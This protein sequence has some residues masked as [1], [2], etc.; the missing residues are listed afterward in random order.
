MSSLFPPQPSRS[1]VGRGPHARRGWAVQRKRA[2]SH[3]QRQREDRNAR[4][5]HAQALV[6]SGVAVAGAELAPTPRA[7]GI[8]PAYGRARRGSARHASGGYKRQQ[9]LALSWNRTCRR[10]VATSAEYTRAAP[11]FYRPASGCP[12]RWQPRS[13][14]KFHCARPVTRFCFQAMALFG[15]GCSTGSTGSTGANKRV[16]LH[17]FYHGLCWATG[18]HA[19]RSNM[20]TG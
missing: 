8:A 15:C 2:E 10:S 16:G 3:R 18:A 5:A 6:R 9:R 12:H 20:Y 11:L 17:L 7:G 4:R 13:E 14:Q 19:R 1:T